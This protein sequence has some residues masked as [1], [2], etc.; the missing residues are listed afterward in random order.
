MLQNIMAYED[1]LGLPKERTFY[2][3][4]LSW[5]MY[6]GRFNMMLKELIPYL[7]GFAKKNRIFGAVWEGVEANLGDDLMETV[8]TLDRSARNLEKDLFCEL[9]E[10]SNSTCDAVLEQIWEDNGL[11][12]NRDTVSSDTAVTF[13]AL[14]ALFLLV[15][16]Q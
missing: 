5:L 7:E 14:L 2:T 13:S 16:S 9:P 4:V 6:S 10:G 1:S 11:P 12:P 3:G 15:I 8:D